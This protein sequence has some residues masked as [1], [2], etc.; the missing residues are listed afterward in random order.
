MN[1]RSIE[2]VNELSDLVKK[3]GEIYL[4][5]LTAIFFHLTEI[6]IGLW[7]TYFRGCYDIQSGNSIR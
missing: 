7:I 6:T 3:Q 5:L 4:E 2:K 1:I